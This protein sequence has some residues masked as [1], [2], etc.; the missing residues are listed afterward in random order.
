MMRKL[1]NSGQTSGTVS[2]AAWAISSPVAF[3]MSGAILLEQQRIAEIRPVRVERCARAVV[4]RRRRV[5]CCE[6]LVGLDAVGDARRGV[7]DQFGDAGQ[8]A[9]ERARGDQPEDARELD[10]RRS[11]GRR[12]RGWRTASAPPAPARSRTSPPSRR[13]SSSG[14]RSRHSRSRRRARRPRA[15][16]R[17]RSWRPPPSSAW[18]GH[19]ACRCSR[20]RR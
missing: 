17:G 5:I 1:Q 14:F 11:A 6:R 7:L 18:P 2:S 3:S 8:V 9:V 15:P 16:R 10:L 19:G 13:S 20:N 4:V 12:R